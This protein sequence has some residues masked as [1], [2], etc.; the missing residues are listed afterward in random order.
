[1]LY[2]QQLNN[3]FNAQ[4]EYKSQRDANFAQQFA[5]GGQIGSWVIIED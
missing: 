3:L 4:E 5:Q 2:N 1:M